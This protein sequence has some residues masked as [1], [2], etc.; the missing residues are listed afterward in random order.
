ME[1]QLG[2][3][4]KLGLEADEVLI[5]SSFHARHLLLFKKAVSE[6]QIYACTCSRKEVLESLARMASAP[7]GEPPLYTGHC[8]GVGRGVRQQ[9]TNNPSIAWR[10]KMEDEGGQHD[11]IMGRTDP[12]GGEFVPSYNWACAIDDHD[13]G[14]ELLVRAW[15]LAH[16]ASQQRAI[17][18]WISTAPPPAV[19]Y[20]SLVT[21]NDGKRLEK[22]T[23]GITLGELLAS[24]LSVEAML[25][26]FARSFSWRKEDYSSGALFGEAQK[27][28]T[29]A[30][31]GF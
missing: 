17:H 1:R 26:R 16:V 2:E 25:E 22:R 13:G 4:R 23:P 29:L 30:E 5:Q 18:G 19:F 24:G 6:G 12:D 10:F 9:E 3:M 20:T 11:F 7:H 31:L 14:Y 28:I 21:Q 8:R 15:D 27:R